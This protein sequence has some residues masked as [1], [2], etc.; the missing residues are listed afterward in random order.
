MTHE[1][2][3]VKIPVDKTIAPIVQYI[4][5]NYMYNLIPFASCEG[6][7]NSQAYISLI[8]RDMPSL[9]SLLSK[10]GAHHYGIQVT[11]DAPIG[12]IV[13]SSFD[14][15]WP[16]QNTKSLL[17]IVEMHKKHKSKGTTKEYNE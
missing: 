10:L 6:D 9:E 7:N 17:S 5:D 16:V 1:T 11:F 4:I 3:N 13:V 12:N 8:V 2:T 14:L 15:R